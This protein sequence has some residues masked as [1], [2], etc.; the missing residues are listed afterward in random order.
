V[1]PLISQMNQNVLV[2]YFTDA[3]LVGAPKIEAVAEALT[4]T[5]K[6]AEHGKLLLNFQAVKLMT[7]SMLG[8]LL[9]LQKQCAA[10]KVTLKL[11]CLTGDI[12]EVFEVTRLNKVF[13]IYD[14][15]AAAMKSYGRLGRFFRR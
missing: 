8:K 14:D 3:N 12:L 15:E 6:R 7:S 2:V 9:A 5:M 13:D 11:C 10:A 1:E 4:E